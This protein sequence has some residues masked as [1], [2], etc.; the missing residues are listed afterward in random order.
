MGELLEIEGS[1]PYFASKYLAWFL[2][3]W[4]NIIVGRLIIRGHVVTLDTV[5][6][7]PNHGRERLQI[8]KLLLDRSNLNSQTDVHLTQQR[9]KVGLLEA[10]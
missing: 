10:P 1:C 6:H 9:E 7:I 5:Q 3:C 2:N 4:K 8:V